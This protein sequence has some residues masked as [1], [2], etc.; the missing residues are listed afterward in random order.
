MLGLIV[1]IIGSILCSYIF[2]MLLLAIINIEFGILFRYQSFWIG[3]HYSKHCKRYCLNIV[4]CC[5]LWW[6]VDGIKPDL[7]LM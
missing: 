2:I 3:L 5:T 6:T 1:I 7:K 4:P